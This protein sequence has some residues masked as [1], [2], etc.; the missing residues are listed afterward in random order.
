MPL[1]SLCLSDSHTHPPHHTEMFPTCSPKDNS[2][3]LCLLCKNGSGFPLLWHSRSVRSIWGLYGQQGALAAM[4]LGFLVSRRI[5]ESSRKENVILNRVHV[6]A[7]AGLEFFRHFCYSLAICWNGVGCVCVSFPSLFTVLDRVSYHPQII[8]SL[9]IQLSCKSA[10]KRW[11]A[12]CKILNCFLHFGN[13]S[14]PLK[15]CLYISL[16][17]QLQSPWWLT[18]CIGIIT[19]LLSVLP[20]ARW[21]QFLL[22]TRCTSC[23]C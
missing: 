13:C 19:L 1:V 11:T 3:V 20:V 8:G 9:Y 23:L 17:G 18:F 14:G 21:T 4:C 22:I 5:T 10:N 6:N 2:K 16:D 7:E 12:K 15:S